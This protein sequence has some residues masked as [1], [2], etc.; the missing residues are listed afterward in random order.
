M[1]GDRGGPTITIPVSHRPIRQCAM[2]P[3]LTEMDQMKIKMK[4]GLHEQLI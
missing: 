4:A 3:L 1:C 2:P